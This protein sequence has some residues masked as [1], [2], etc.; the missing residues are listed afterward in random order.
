M[1][2]LG[3]IYGG[4]PPPPIPEPSLSPSLNPFGRLQNLLNLP[5]SWGHPKAFFGGGEGPKFMGGVLGVTP[6]SPKPPPT[7]LVLPLMFLG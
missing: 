7:P 4:L 3:V 1:R 5:N 2:S 6:K